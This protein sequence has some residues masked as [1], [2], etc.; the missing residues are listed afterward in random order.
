MIVKEGIKFS[1]E[2]ENTGDDM[3]SLKEASREAIYNDIRSVIAETGASVEVFLQELDYNGRN[4]RT[5]R[6]IIDGEIQDPKLEFTIELLKKIR[7]K[8]FLPVYCI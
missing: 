3:K 1:P 4:A 6:R 5:V 7:E 8:Y 2:K